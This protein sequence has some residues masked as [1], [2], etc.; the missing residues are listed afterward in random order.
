MAMTAVKITRTSDCGKAAF[1]AELET[2]DF[3]ERDLDVLACLANGH[4]NKV[5]AHELQ[6]AESTVKFHIR[7][8]KEKIGATNRTEVALWA[9]SR[10]ITISGGTRNA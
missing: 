3:S 9:A 10:R 8:I 5:I 6:I 2:F 4:S 7:R 1:M